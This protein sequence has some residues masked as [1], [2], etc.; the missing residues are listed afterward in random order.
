MGLALIIFKFAPPPASSLSARPT[1]QDSVESIY[2]SFCPPTAYAQTGSTEYRIWSYKID[3][4][5][6][7]IKQIM[8]LGLEMLR[9]I[10]T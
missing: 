3:A 10:N 9:L 8:L 6:M 2:V 5:T 1:H 4:S 7:L